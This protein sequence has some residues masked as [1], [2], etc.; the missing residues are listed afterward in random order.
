MRV[1][2]LPDSNKVIVRNFATF[3]LL[4]HATHYPTTTLHTQ[5]SSIV[6]LSCMFLDYFLYINIVIWRRN[7]YIVSSFKDFPLTFQ[8]CI[9]K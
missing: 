6:S 1:S 3:K 2:V 8:L 7:V 5:N 4:A 9:F